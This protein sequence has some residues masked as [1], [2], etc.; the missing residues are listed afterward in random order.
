MGLFSSNN[1]NRF[2][3][4]EVTSTSQLEEILNG[5]GCFLFFKH[6]KRCGISIMA[7]NNFENKWDK[8]LKCDLYFID[9]LKHRDVSNLLAEKTN[10][11]H[12]SPQVI[13][14]NKNEVIYHASHGDISPNQ[15][16]NL[17]SNP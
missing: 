5:T 11:Q 8:N 2:P 4:E 10:V 15:I 7:L 3:W 1:K 9:L 12:Q 16:K 17:I 6:S 13:V 14:L